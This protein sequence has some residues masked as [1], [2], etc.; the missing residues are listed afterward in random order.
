[1]RITDEVETL[2]SMIV[3]DPELLVHKIYESWRRWENGEFNASDRFIIGL[4]YSE[5]L[6]SGSSD[7]D[8]YGAERRRGI[9]LKRL[10]VTRE[11]VNNTLRE[12]YNLH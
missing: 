6:A 8:Y 11:Y 4:R 2:R 10:G 9:Y 12:I 3:I 1:M 7:E 5:F